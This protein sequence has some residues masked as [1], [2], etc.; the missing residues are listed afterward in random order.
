MS[1]G[2]RKGGISPYDRGVQLFP[3]THLGPYELTAPLDAGGMGSVWRAMDA[4]LAREVAVKVLPVSV[5]DD[6][7]KVKRFQREAQ[8][9]A[10]LDHPNVVAIYDTGQQWVDARSPLGKERVLVHFLVEEM[11]H[12]PSLRKVLRSGRPPVGWL[13]DVALGVTR[14]LAAAHEKGLVHRDL[15]PENILVDAE[16]VAKIA[17][18]G[19]VRFIYPETAAPAADAAGPPSTD[20][21]DAVPR[22]DARV[23]TLTRTGFVV[24]TL[25]YM[26]PEQVRGEKVGPE[27]DLFSLGIVLYE[28]LTG[29]P[30]FTVPETDPMSA[31]LT[32]NPRPAE[33]IVP[34]TP[35]LLAKI[36]EKCLRKEKGRRYRS[37]RELERDLL[38]LRREV[39]ATGTG[40]QVL[41]AVAGRRPPPSPLWL[42]LAAVAVLLS[43]LAG[44]G[45]RSIIL[46][47]APRSA[48]P[49]GGGTDR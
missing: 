43:F 14:G 33:E 7:R 35:R 27:S 13:V 8:A 45:V 30:P 44:F 9:A 2:R 47:S 32:V 18:F 4:R 15:K 41:P 6:D 28:M 3:G 46:N 25:G 48:A 20:G 42:L 49:A 31:I 11:V 5:T 21:T 12:G 17:D 23:E 26:S 10:V 29:V 38:D 1:A 24:G 37:A 36:L 19:L 16:G 39:E 22:R 40:S 34:E